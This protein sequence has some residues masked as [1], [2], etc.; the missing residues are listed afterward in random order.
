MFGYKLKTIFELDTVKEPCSLVMVVFEVSLSNASLPL[1][2]PCSANAWGP[3]WG[4]CFMLQAPGTMPQALCYRLYATGSMLQALC[5][6]LKALCSMLHSTCYMLYATCY[7]LH[8][9]WSMLHACSCL[10]GPWR[11][12]SWLQVLREHTRELGGDAEFLGAVFT[13]EPLSGALIR[14]RHQGKGIVHWSWS[15][16]SFIVIIN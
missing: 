12:E 15:C 5:Y 6:R 11:G 13:L 1:S 8:V 3:E 9:T 2:A 16:G 10:P 14:E 7:M 4:P